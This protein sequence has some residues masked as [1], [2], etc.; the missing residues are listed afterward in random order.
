MLKEPVAL[1]KKIQEKS[2]IN[3]S[4]VKRAINEGLDMTSHEG[5]DFEAEM[6][7]LNSTKEDKNDGGARFS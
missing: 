6:V 5:F 7:G 2:L 3:L 4:Y 1:I